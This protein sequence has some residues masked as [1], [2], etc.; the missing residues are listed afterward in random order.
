MAIEASLSYIAKSLGGKRG[1]RMEEKKRGREEEGRKK[2]KM[3]IVSWQ[4]L[5]LG[6]MAVLTLLARLEHNAKTKD[7]YTG[8]QRTY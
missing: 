6:S 2:N 8:P 5:T 1:A 4:E 7:I 3:G